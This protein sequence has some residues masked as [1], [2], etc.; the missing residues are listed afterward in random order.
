MGDVTLSTGKVVSIDTSKFTWKEWRGFFSGR[1]SQKEEDAF[2][3][4]ASGLNAKEQGDLL[5]DD[6]RRIVEAIRK[7]GSEPL[8]DPLLVSQST[9]D[10]PDK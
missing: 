2:I 1:A 5:R 8:A 10:S 9:E 3:E 7:V 6:F 4:K